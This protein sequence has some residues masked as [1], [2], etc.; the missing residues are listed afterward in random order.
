LISNFAAMTLIS[1][2][3]SFWKASLGRV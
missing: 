3:I 1:R 2:R